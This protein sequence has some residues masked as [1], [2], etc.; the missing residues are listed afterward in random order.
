[1]Q[2]FFHKVDNMNDHFNKIS[3]FYSNIMLK[4]RN[5]II[6]TRLEIVSS[7]KYII[8][9]SQL[10]HAGGESVLRGPVDVAA[11]L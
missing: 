10:N 2:V 7:D 8:L 5:N 3:L 4:N 9:L 11:A 6:L 1:M